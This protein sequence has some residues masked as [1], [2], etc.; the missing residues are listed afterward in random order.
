MSFCGGNFWKF[1]LA[2]GAKKK[3]GPCGPG[4]SLPAETDNHLPE[5]NSWLHTCR[6]LGGTATRLPTAQIEYAP[7][8]AGE[9]R[10]RPHVS[11]DGVARRADLRQSRNSLRESHGCATSRRTRPASEIPLLRLRGQKV[12]RGL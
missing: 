7:H 3:P 11:H 6:H 5:G 2:G 12:A 1:L 4:C 9:Q 8:R 10:G